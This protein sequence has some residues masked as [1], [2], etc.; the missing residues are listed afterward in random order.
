MARNELVT[1][2]NGFKDV[3]VK[4][5]MIVEMQAHR[6]QRLGHILKTERTE[7]SILLIYINRRTY[8]EGPS[9]DLRMVEAYK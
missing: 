1:K 2:K 9:N 7:K 3:L 5:N 8:I 4:S 6:H